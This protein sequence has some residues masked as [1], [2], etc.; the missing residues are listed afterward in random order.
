MFSIVVANGRVHLRGVK[1][2][3]GSSKDMAKFKIVCIC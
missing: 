1:G 2:L 3:K